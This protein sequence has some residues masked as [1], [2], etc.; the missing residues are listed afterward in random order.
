M[1]LFFISI[2]NCAAMHTNFYDK[3]KFKILFSINLIYYHFQF[4]ADNTRLIYGIMTKE[5]K[6]SQPI[7]NI[8]LE[9][10]LS[11]K[12]I[13]NQYSLSVYWQIYIL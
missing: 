9:F 8:A 4:Q 12:P 6:S 1:K 7:I 10:Y 2:I 11:L 5:K 3:N 13:V